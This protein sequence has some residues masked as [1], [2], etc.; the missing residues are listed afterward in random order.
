M[1]VLSLGIEERNFQHDEEISMR[2][3]IAWMAASLLTACDLSDPIL[4]TRSIP[5]ILAS[6]GPSDAERA[7]C[8]GRSSPECR[9]VNSPVELV[10]EPVRLPWRSLV[11]YPTAE[12]LTFVDGKGRAWVAPERTLTDGA[13][14]PQM[15]ISIVGAPTSGQFANAAAVHDAYC[16]VGNEEGPKFHAAPWRDVHRMFYDALRVGG[17]P[18]TKAKVM[19]AAVYLGG[20]RWPGEDVDAEPRLSSRG[21]LTG[22]A[23]REDVSPARYLSEPELRRIMRRTRD[24]VETVEP[25]LSQIETVIDMGVSESAR[26][27]AHANGQAG[28]V[29]G[30]DAG[31]GTGDVTGEDVSPGE[32]ASPGAVVD[33]PSPGVAL[34]G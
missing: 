28:T 16:G 24:L 12:P 33:A 19:Y 30:E 25:S 15:F 29:R 4:A 10:P 1:K 32:D 22:L 11:F 5:K 26:Q 21:S 14:I 20:P 31:D 27:A 18:E 8:R 9:F 7:L 3:L 13:S 23:Q 34:P 2:I 6:V 17:T